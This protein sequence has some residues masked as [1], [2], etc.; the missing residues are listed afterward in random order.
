MA[1]LNIFSKKKTEDKALKIIVDNR[2]RNSLIPSLL[3]ERGFEIEWQ[4]LPVGDYLVNNIAIERKT[5]SDFKSSIIN[6]RIISQLLELKQYPKNLL[7]IEGL[8][9]FDLYY[10]EEQNMHE[11]AVRGFLLS[12]ALEFQVPVIF[13][14]SSEDTSKYLEILAKKPQNKELSIRASKLV[15][16]DKERIQFIL[17]GFPTIGPKS[18]KK[19]I[20][21]F[22]SLKNI[23]TANEEDLARIVGKSKASNL[24]SI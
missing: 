23:L 15:K 5:V 7:I 3:M 2:E 1:L 9:D 17:E 19:L 20:S 22:K 21:E 10:S 4:Q 11:N 24:K 13:T 14:Q 8:E 16:S 6:K 12:V 18:A